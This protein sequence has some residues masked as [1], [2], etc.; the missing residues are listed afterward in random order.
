VRALAW[1]GRDLIGAARRHSAWAGAAAAL[2]PSPV[3][4]TFLKGNRPMKRQGFT[5]IELLVV[6]AI[7]A[8]LI[9]L[10]LPAVQ[11]AREA[12]RRMQCTN[13]LKQIGIAVQ[14]Y[15]D[16]NSGLP[17]TSTAGPNDFSMK[18]RILPFIEQGT[19]YNT[20]N[21]NFV[22]SHPS[23]FTAHVAQINTFNC[24]SDGNI[25]SVL[26]T[27]PTNSS[28]NIL[29]GYA[30]YPNNIGTVYSNNGGRYDGPA[31]KMGDT[32][33][34][35]P[36]SL[37]S[38]TDGT[39]NTV[40]FSEFVRGKGAGNSTQLGLHQI[41]SSSVPLQ[42]S[43]YSYQNPDVAFIPGCKAAKT[44]FLWDSTAQS[45]TI[46]DRKGEAYYRQNC[47]E[48]GGY[49]HIMPP[50]TNACFWKGD[51]QT[52]TFETMVS[53]SS[54]HSGGVN[55]LMLDGSVHFIKNSISTVTWRAI[56]TYA[57]GEVIS[58]DSL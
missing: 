9:A 8:V 22:G 3:A 4:P 51:D 37:A 34:S 54:Y 30:S 47:G 13:N 41:Y 57:G 28:I 16:A 23:N 52:H 11:A 25:P 48:G 6:I 1:P 49:S 14:N 2:L 40:I 31:Y 12:A 15:H 24:P 18:V 35:I 21:M 44:P 17:P 56:A 5:L 10:L 42:G 39:S 33:H 32:S 55:V 53:A 26:K 29:L 38:I 36:L 19:I 7:I 27:N 20:F 45:P 58:A 50:N 43:P 46:A